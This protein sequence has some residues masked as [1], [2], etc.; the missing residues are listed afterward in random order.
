VSELVSPLRSDLPVTVTTGS[1]ESFE[2]D[3]VSGPPAFDIVFAVRLDRLTKR[4]CQSCGRRR[5]VFALRGYAG[6]VV[7][8]TS[9]RLCSRCAG[10]VG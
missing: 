6:S 10:L 9:K 4:K 2:V 1:G 5:I 7:I 8:S 3:I